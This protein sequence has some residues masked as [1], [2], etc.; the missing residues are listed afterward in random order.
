MLAVPLDIVFD[1]LCHVVVIGLGLVG[2]LGYSNG[3]REDQPLL[4]LSTAGLLLGMVL[5]AAHFH[6]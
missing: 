5:M 2:V 4:A 1:L 6:R 3:R